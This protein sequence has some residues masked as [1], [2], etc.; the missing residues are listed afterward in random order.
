MTPELVRL[1]CVAAVGIVSLNRPPVNVLNRAVLDALDDVLR[2]VANDSDIRAVVL[3][4]GDRA[5]SAGA[6]IREFGSLVDPT[7]IHAWMTRG[8]RVISGIARFRKPIIAAIE[9][10]CFGGG[11][12]VALG[13]HLRCA[14]ESA[15]LGLPEIKLGIVPGFGGTQRLPRL[16]GPAN[17]TRMMLTGEPT[18]GARALDLG[19]VDQLVPTGEARTAAIALAEILSQ[20]S[21]TATAMIL[22]LVEAAANLPLN[23]GLSR[24]IES[25]VR[26]VRSDDG[27]EGIAAFLAKRAARFK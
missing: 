7:E 3:T 25:E 26:A 21:A 18:T 15:E 4:G 24:E 19:L 27:Q 16:I 11:L 10:Y 6:D 20:R 8:H 22:D 17:A 5:F 2:Q 14:A 13:C 12:E 1:E 9:G 23:E